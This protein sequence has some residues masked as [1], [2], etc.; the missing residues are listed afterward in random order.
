[1]LA[2]ERMRRPA[3]ALGPSMQQLAVWLAISFETGRAA[4]AGGRGG[5]V[6]STRA[7]GEAYTVQPSVTGERMSL[8]T[9]CCTVWLIRA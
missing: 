9:I 5:R 4:R 6:V 7:C 3:A 1:M 2:V 8:G